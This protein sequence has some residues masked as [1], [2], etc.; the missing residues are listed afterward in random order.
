MVILY[1]VE[2]L[3]KGGSIESREGIV[4]FRLFVR[5]FARS[6]DEAKIQHSDEGL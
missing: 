6:I 3:F 2:H 4:E 1:Q 5:E